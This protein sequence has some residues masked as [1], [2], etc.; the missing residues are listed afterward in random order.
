[1]TT[2]PSYPID[3]AAISWVDSNGI[4][5]LHVFSSDGYN[6]TQR[7]W[8]GSGWAT[9]SFAAPGSQV[10]ATV[11]VLQGQPYLRVYC[12]SDDETTEYCQDAGGSWYQGAYTT[13]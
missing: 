7:Y 2:T 5:Q 13:S 10:S 6:V 9:G 1:M 8:A 12:N 11:Y 4:A 3:T